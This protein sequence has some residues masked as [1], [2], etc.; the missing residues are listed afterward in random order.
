MSSTDD[1]NVPSVPSDSPGSSVSTGMQEEYEELLRY[2]VVTPKIDPRPIEEISGIEDERSEVNTGTQ[3][4]LYDESSVTT[5]SSEEATARR[6]EEMKALRREDLIMTLPKPGAPK[7][8]RPTSLP[9][10]LSSPS[11]T[12]GQPRVSGEGNVQADE[13]GD[14]CFSD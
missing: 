9:A 6:V 5:E 10:F 12:P 7:P 1:S 14:S 11:T 2:A 13:R 3:A 4:G 8:Q